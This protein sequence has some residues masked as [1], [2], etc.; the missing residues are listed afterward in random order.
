MS[1]IDI[2]GTHGSGKSWIMH[3]LIRLYE[4]EPLLGGDG[5]PLGYELKSIDA[6]IIGKYSNVCGGCDQIGKPEEIV[7]RVRLFTASYT[8]VLLEGILVAHT[9]KRYH[10]LAIELTES[11]VVDNYHF[12]FLNTPLKQCISRAIARRKAKGNEKPFNPTHLKHDYRQIW[13]NVR[14]NC[15]KHDLSVVELDWKN[16]IPQV[17][18]LLN[19]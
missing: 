19:A 1:V 7:R 14:A 8:H 12:C 18:E 3:E 2:R 13:T 5:K 17:L 10:E 9:F 15:Y 4:G 11:G 6:I 16:P